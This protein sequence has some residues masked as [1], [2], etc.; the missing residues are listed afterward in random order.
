[1]C[2]SRTSRNLA[3]AL[4]TV[5]LVFGL[6]MIPATPSAQ[7]G[8]LCSVP[9]IGIACSVVS[10]VESGVSWTFDT[11]SSVITSK[12]AEPTSS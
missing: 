2:G 1:M 12:S 8:G 10:G 7:A 6:R 9:V 11:G 5:T 3:V 4:A